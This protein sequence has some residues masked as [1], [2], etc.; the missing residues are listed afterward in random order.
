[1]PPRAHFILSFEI[2]DTFRVVFKQHLHVLVR[3]TRFP[4]VLKLNSHLEEVHSLT[5]FPGKS[6][7]LLSALLC[8]FL[9]ITRRAS[10]FTLLR[11]C[12]VEEILSPSFDV[13][14]RFYWLKLGQTTPDNRLYLEPLRVWRPKFERRSVGRES[15]CSL[16]EVSWTE[17][18]HPQIK[19]DEKR[20]MYLVASTE[21]LIQTSKSRKK[22]PNWKQFGHSKVIQFRAQLDARYI[23]AVSLKSLALLEFSW[24]TRSESF[25]FSLI[26][27][28]TCGDGLRDRRRNYCQEIAFI[29][30]ETRTTFLPRCEIIHHRGWHAENLPFIGPPSPDTIFSA[31]S[32]FSSSAPEIICV[33]VTGLELAKR[34]HSGPR[35]IHTCLFRCFCRITQVFKQQMQVFFAFCTEIENIFGVLF[36]SNYAGAFVT[37]CVCQWSFWTH[38]VHELKHPN[39]LQKTTF[40]SLSTSFWGQLSPWLNSRAQTPTLT[41]SHHGATC[42][43]NSKL[44]KKILPE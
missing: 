24:W 39:I 11:D 5:L 3:E 42:T 31:C 34:A 9:A 7:R 15:T 8:I 40:N 35:L 37:G 27:P 4:N 36:D 33:C 28:H 1:M 26:G 14:S 18:R 13:L 41:T 20:N 30:C 38:S 16:G 2:C 12:G 32:S 21:G 43:P 22:M 10:S 17:T 19:T 6:L 29:D 23:S 44:E 25:H